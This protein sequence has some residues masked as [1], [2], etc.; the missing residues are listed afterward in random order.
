MK[1]RVSPIKGHPMDPKR[2][3]LTGDD[4]LHGGRRLSMKKKVKNMTTTVDRN[5]VVV[6]ERRNKVLKMNSMN[7][8]LCV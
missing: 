2:L 4:D 7:D 8:D 1:S 5:I 6:V 3:V